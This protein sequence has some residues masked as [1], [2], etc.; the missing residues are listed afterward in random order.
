M[1]TTHPDNAAHNG[2]TSPDGKIH[3]TLK[4]DITATCRTC[5]FQKLKVTATEDGSNPDEAFV[6]FVAD[7]KIVGQKGDRQAGSKLQQL[8]ERSRFLRVDGK[9]MYIDGVNNWEHHTYEKK[10][11]DAVK[12]ATAKA[13]QKINEGN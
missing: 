10:M 11:E 8:K 4:A 7:F 6:S 12:N 9:W 3:T 1:N 5:A 2:T 13:V